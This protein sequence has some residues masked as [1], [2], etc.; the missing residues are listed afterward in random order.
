MSRRRVL[1]LL[2]LT[3]LLVVAFAVGLLLVSPDRRSYFASL[4]VVGRWIESLVIWEDGVVVSD[5]VLT[6]SFIVDGVRKSLGEKG[7]VTIDQAWNVGVGESVVVFVDGNLMVNQPSD[8]AVG[9]FLALIVN[10]DIV[11]QSDT[12]EGVFVA[13]GQIVTRG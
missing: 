4:P 11:F 12:A 1:L 3:V 10:G 13:E 6:N 2:I 5:E 8:V 9:G 7:E